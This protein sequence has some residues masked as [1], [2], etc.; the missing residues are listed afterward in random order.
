M[1]PPVQKDDL[2]PVCWVDIHP[3]EEVPKL[4]GWQYMLREVATV[5]KKGKRR[6]YLAESH[7]AEEVVRE[8]LSAEAKLVGHQD[9]LQNRC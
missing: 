5:G 1:A 2:C 7:K 4:P 8:E 6:K 3:D 9:G